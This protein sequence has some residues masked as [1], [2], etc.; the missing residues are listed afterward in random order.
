MPVVIVDKH[1]DVVSAF[2]KLK[3][4]C[5]DVLTKSPNKNDQFHQKKSV[6]KRRSKLAAIAREKKR[7]QR[8]LAKLKRFKTKSKR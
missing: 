3:K 2:R 7:Q 1:R 8:L 4:L 5:G 6:K